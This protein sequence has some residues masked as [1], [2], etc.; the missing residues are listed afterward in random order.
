M[1]RKKSQM[2][3]IFMM[4]EEVEFA[5][6]FIK[7]DGNLNKIVVKINKLET[8]L[9]FKQNEPNVPSWVNIFKPILSII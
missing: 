2:L 9:Y 8:Y 1:A 3:S 7:D 4:K 6:K 5:S